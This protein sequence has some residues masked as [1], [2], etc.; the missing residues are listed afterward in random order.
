MSFNSNAL[1][2]ILTLC[3]IA[4]LLLA[5]PIEQSEDGTSSQ[6]PHADLQIESSESNEGASK[7]EARFGGDDEEEAGTLEGEQGSF[8]QGDID[9][10]PDQEEALFSNDTEV[11]LDESTRTG[12]LA[13]HYRWPK[14]SKGQVVVPYTISS[15]AG[16]SKFINL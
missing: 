8:F 14:N 3:L 1:G 12:L 11:S 2:T 4:S 16:Y 6:P 10:E 15:N 5:I 9:L 13:Q 7:V